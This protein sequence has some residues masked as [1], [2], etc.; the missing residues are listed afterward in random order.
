MFGVHGDELFVDAINIEFFLINVDDVI[1]EGL[2][3]FVVGN[4][5][6]QLF[7]VLFGASIDGILDEV[8]C[9][10]KFQQGADVRF[11]RGVDRGGRAGGGLGGGLGLGGGT[12]LE[13]TGG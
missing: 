4:G 7:A 8:A 3:F 13:W 12:A 9:A 1:G 5:S 6:D 11:F 2:A 10:D